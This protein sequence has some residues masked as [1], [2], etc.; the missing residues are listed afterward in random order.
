[1]A[2]A[3]TARKLSEVIDSAQFC[4]LENQVIVS[5]ALEF[6]ESR[7]HSKYGGGSPN[8]NPTIREGAV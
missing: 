5:V 4:R 2:I 1:M 7:R 6:G 3:N 8:R